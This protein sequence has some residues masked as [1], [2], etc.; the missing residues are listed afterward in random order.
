MKK[1][2]NLNKTNRLLKV[3]DQPC[4]ALVRKV[5]VLA[6][7]PL[8]GLIKMAFYA[9][10]SQAFSLISQLSFICLKLSLYLFTF[11]TLI[12]YYN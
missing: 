8:S 1:K 12:F 7:A 4:H 10:R 2:K 6:I 3:R 9:D 5:L 11:Y